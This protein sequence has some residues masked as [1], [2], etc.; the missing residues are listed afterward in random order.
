MH[1]IAQKLTVLGIGLGTSAVVGWLLL[2]ESKRQDS[3]GTVVV[4]SQR[5]AGEPDE[6]EIVVPLDTINDEENI[7]LTTVDNEEYEDDL[8]QIN[9]IG[10][11]FAEALKASGITQF[12]QL[13]QQTPESLSERLAN[14][15]TVRP[16]R[17]RDKDWI[18]QAAQ[19]LVQSSD[20]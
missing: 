15:V 18:G 11:R 19:M 6:I 13:A 3:A 14:H 9:D 12:S 4:K 20:S 5:H 16:Q 1:K 8:T 10:P 17:I 7:V 2:R